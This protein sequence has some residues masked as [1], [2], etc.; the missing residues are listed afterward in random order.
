MIEAL[1]RDGRCTAA[2]IARGTGQSPATARRYLAKVLNS[3]LVAIRCDLAQAHSGFPITVQWFT[4]LPASEHGA[5]AQRLKA[6]LNLRMMAST[7]GRANFLLTMWLPSV[8]DILAAERAIE[9][10]VPGIEILES[11]VMMQP[12]KRLGWV[13]NPDSTRSARHIPPPVSVD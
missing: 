8:N 13:I 4:R 11:S 6:N 2:E 12:L 5:A 10:T 9:L 7:T 1:Q 3:G